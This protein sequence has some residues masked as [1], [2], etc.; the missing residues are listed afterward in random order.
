MLLVETVRKAG[1]D[2]A[3]SAVLA[4]WRKQ[5]TENDPDKILLDVV[6]ADALGGDCL[7]DV[8]ILRADS[9]VLGPVASDPTVSPLIKT[10]TGNGK[11]ALTA[12][13]H[14]HAH[15]HVRPWPGTPPHD[16]HPS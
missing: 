11:G 13:R 4:P 6:L 16:H 5:R 2:S 9:A 10:L 12:I 8:A 7:A 3:I 15:E 14:A 1:Q